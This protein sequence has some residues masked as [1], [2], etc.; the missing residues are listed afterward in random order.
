MILYF[1]PAYV[2]ALIQKEVAQ[3]ETR[4]RSDV[5]QETADAK[6]VAHTAETHGRLALAGVGRAEVELNK[7]GFDIDLTGH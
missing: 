1:G 3:A 2:E 5:A 7:K 4:I 6:A